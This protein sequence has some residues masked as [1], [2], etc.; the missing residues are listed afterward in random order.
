MGEKRYPIKIMQNLS[1]ILFSEKKLLNFATREF[2][3]RLLSTN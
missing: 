2:L 1:E 3:D